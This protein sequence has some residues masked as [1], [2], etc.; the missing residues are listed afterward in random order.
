MPDIPPL[1]EL[2]FAEIPTVSRPRYSGDRFSYMQAGR[3]DLPPV[4]LLHGIGANSLHW[5]YQ[6]AGLA[7][8]F[9]VVAWN[10]PG[11]M[12]S[13]NLRAETPSGR[14]YADAL[15]DFLKALGIAGFDVVANSFGTRVAQ[16]YAYHYP[17]RIG[18]AVFTGT[19]LARAAPPEERA[20]ALRARAS[21]IERGG[22]GFGE[23]VTALVG[24]AASPETIALEQHT[25]RATNPAGHAGGA[26]PDGRR[27]ARCRADDATIANPRCRGSGDAGRRKCRAARQRCARRDACDA[28]W[29]WPPARGGGAGAGQR[30]D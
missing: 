9:R 26:I 10:A 5:R 29:L 28:R 6:L 8:R 30:A 21:M 15:D 13:D 1:P 24:S 25:L 7:S 18:R 22:Y 23:R 17:G 16:S 12:L 2:H 27:K 20:Q 11:Y 14:D 19:S 4:V 3:R